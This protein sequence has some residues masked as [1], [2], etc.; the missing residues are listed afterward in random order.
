MKRIYF[1]FPVLVLILFSCSMEDPDSG[2]TGGLSSS[3]SVIDTWRVSY[4]WDS[5]NSAQS[6]DVTFFE[7]GTCLLN[8]DTGDSSLTAAAT[9]TISGNSITW[10]YTDTG[11]V[12]N[13]TIASDWQTM[14]GTMS[15]VFYGTPSDGTWSAVR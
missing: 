2:L 6:S 7:D 13:G 12:Y 5:M 3:N 9:W 15:I 14:S 10:T 1:L 4:Q 8:N 11:A